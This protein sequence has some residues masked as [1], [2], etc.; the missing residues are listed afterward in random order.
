VP[1]AW[2]SFFGPDS[3]LDELQLLPKLSAPLLWVAGSDDRGQDDAAERFGRTPA[4]PMN[5]F[6]MV[7]ADHFRTPEVALP[8]VISW[9][10]ELQG[11]LDNPGNRT[12]P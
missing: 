9:L 10:S 12:T 6:I 4:T 7:K 5:R 2:L 8:A 11:W 1:R 3:P